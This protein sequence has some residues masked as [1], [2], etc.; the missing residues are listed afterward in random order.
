MDRRK[1]GP[2]CIW[3]LYIQTSGKTHLI[4]SFYY[5]NIITISDNNISKHFLN[6]LKYEDKGTVKGVSTASCFLS[7]IE[8]RFLFPTKEALVIGVSWGFSD[9]GAVR[10]ER[11]FGRGWMTESS[12]GD[13]HN[14]IGE[15]KKTYHEECHSHKRFVGLLE[16]CYV[17]S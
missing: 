14:P 9:A 6:F 15:S 13:I 1:T 12:Y 16:L 17:L 4:C 2:T 8:Y 7:R 10:Y 11:N 3:T 5:N